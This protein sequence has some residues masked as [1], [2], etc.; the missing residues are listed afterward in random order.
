MTFTLVKRIDKAEK[1]FRLLT[2]IDKRNVKACFR[3]SKI[4]YERQ[5]YDEAMLKYINY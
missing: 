1:V 4:L 5:D 2:S 3:L